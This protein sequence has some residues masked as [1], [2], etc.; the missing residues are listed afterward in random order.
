VPP[1]KGLRF[2]QVGADKG[3]AS[4]SSALGRFV[5]RDK[6]SDEAA[7]VTLVGAM[8]IGAGSEEGVISP[9]SGESISIGMDSVGL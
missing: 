6:G 5:P 4:S 9:S 7:M 2:I 3:R 1:P 8:G